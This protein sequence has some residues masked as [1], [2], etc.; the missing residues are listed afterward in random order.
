LLIVSAKYFL[1]IGQYPI[2][3]R[4]RETWLLT[5]CESQGNGADSMERWSD[6]PHGQNVVA[7]IPPSRL[8]GNF[9]SVFETVK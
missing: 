5:F 4:S 8:Y 9:M 3:L 7:A 1:K 6:R 2:K